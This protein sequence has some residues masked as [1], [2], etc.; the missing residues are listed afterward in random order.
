MLDKPIFEA[1]IEALSITEHNRRPDARGVV[2]PF[3][4]VHILLFGDFKQYHHGRT[5]ISVFPCV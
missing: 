4:S 5:N 3:G 2:D 1:I